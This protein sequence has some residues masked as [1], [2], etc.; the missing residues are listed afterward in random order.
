MSRLSELMAKCDDPNVVLRQLRILVIASA[1]VGACAL[2]FACIN[3]THVVHEVQ[4]GGWTQEDAA[5]MVIGFH[6]RYHRFPSSWDEA[7]P[8]YPQREY[9]GHMDPDETK[10]RV[11]IDFDHPPVVPRGSDVLDHK[12]R[13]ISYITPS[14]GRRDW[15]RGAEP[16]TMVLQY[17]RGD[18][19][20]FWTA[21][22]R[23][24]ERR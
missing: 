5:M 10:R 20:S 2:P 8:Y 22:M 4:W 7:L 9:G 12:S 19:R 24:Q 23:E 11:I 14:N 17:L 21:I 13:P 1:V 16:N 3:V 15:W 18:N 6:L